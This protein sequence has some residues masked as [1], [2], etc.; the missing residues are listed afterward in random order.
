MRSISRFLDPADA[1]AASTRGEVSILDSRPMG[2]SWVADRLWERLGIGAG[3]AKMAASRRVDAH[4][5]EGVIFAM[6]ANRLSVKPL[7]KQVRGD[8]ASAD[9]VVGR[10]GTS[11]FA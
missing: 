6:V 1:V 3:M 9:S 4:A 5:V 2:A 8:K 11:T 10:V 7:S